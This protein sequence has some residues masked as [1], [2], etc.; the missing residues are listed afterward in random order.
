MGYNDEGYDYKSLD[1]AA[2]FIHDYCVKYARLGGQAKEKYG[3]VRFY[4]MFGHLSLHSLIYPG[5]YYS[6][7]PKW[8]WNL[9]IYVIPKLLK[10]FERLFFRWQKFIY[11]RAYNLAFKKFPQV[12]KGIA[13]GADY[14]E[15]IKGLTSQTGDTLIILSADKKSVIATWTRS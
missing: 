9:D 6:Q 11:S 13:T 14:P 2:S 1:E 12:Y 4:A 7:F 15:Y 8:L 10:P 3:T 5:Y